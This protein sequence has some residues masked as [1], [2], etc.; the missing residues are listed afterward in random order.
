MFKYLWKSSKTLFAAKLILTLAVS[1][2]LI[3]IPRVVGDISDTLTSGQ[4]VEII[5][6]ILRLLATLA[7]G[8]ILILSRN[9]VTASYN[10][11]VRKELE[12]DL[13]SKLISKT[14]S[15]ADVINIYNQEIS[16][17][18]AD[19]HSKYFEILHTVTTFCLAIAL[20]VSVSYEI[21][22][23]V[24][25]TITIIVLVNQLFAKRLTALTN[26]IQ[27]QNVKMNQMVVGVFTVL[28]TVNIFSYFAPVL[29]KLNA[30]FA[31]RRQ[32]V[33]RK[34]TFDA[35]LSQLNNALGWIVQYGLIIGSYILVYLGKLNIGQ[36]TTLVLLMP[37]MVEPMGSIAEYKNTLTSTKDIRKK[38]MAILNEP[39][40]TVTA[41]LPPSDIALRDVAFSYT[42][43]E[44]FMSGV[45]LTFERGK[46]YLIVG[47]S[48]SG[49]S[50]LLK[51]L[52]KE[53]TPSSGEISYGGV[54]VA[55][56]NTPTWYQNI[57]YTSQKVEILPGT[58]RENIVLGSAYE[59]TKFNNI[60]N[61]LNLNYLR[62]KLDNP[63]NE[64]LSNF[65]GGELQRVAIARMLYDD[66]P[67][68]IFDEFSSALD[69]I[70][71]RQIE[72]ELLKIDDKLLIS[73]THRVQLDLLDSYESVII[74]ENGCV[75]RI[76]SPSE[77][78]DDLRPFLSGEESAA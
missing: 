7:A 66:S 4:K 76:G 37:Y 64:D 31:C 30:V 63:L 60:I 55:G 10:Y 50:T 26:A 71:A 28:R 15:Y 61:L 12:A 42:D 43:E 3:Y 33:K 52:L 40:E 44:D 14:R 24:I 77:M 19:Y 59:E 72:K 45:N 58:L 35:Y 69:N 34:N 74:M 27:D 68:F 51:L 5:P 65:S 29:A 2:I 67:I 22:L 23:W 16:L 18:L 53:L 56:I 17:V 57:A 38:L 21:V 62:D 36:V 20:G 41:K 8:I 46:R 73:V 13:S 54:D 78:M 9:L 47:Q 1:A 6:L 32:A 48:G 25:C 11:Y 75:K 39:D 70:N 49:K